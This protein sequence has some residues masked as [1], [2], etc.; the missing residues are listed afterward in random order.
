MNLDF[1]YN[2]QHGTTK[3]VDELENLFN[4]LIDNLN[5][6]TNYPGWVKGIYPTRE[7]AIHGIEQNN[8][9]VLKVDGKIAGTI[10]L[11]HEPEA[12]YENAKWLIDA[13]DNEVI[14]IHTFA[15]HPDFKNQGIAYKLM[16][17]A[18]EYSMEHKMKS[19]RLDVTIQ[20]KPAISLY[21]KCGYRYID[22]V[23]LG[24]NIPDLI[25]FK[26]Y[27]LVL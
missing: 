13:K 12:V 19:I 17:F 22:T 20:N 21:E 6:N 10:T 2:I 27:E 9:F 3:D 14:V 5:A 4:D 18:K 24:L 25:W 26:L 23:D 16:E 1:N 8:L 15:V 7:T 11:N